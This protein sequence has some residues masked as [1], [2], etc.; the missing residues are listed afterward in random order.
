MRWLPRIIFMTQ[1]QRRLTYHILPEILV[2]THL[3]FHVAINPQSKLYPHFKQLRKRI[4]K[5]SSEKVLK[6]V[7]SKQK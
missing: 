7:A 4:N 6:K 1:V 3:V 2:F 5:L